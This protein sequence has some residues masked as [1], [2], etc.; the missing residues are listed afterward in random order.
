MSQGLCCCSPCR[1]TFKRHVDAIYPANP[2]EGLVKNKMETLA[3]YAMTSPEKLDRIGEYLE[4]RISRDIYRNRKGLAIIGMEAM[5]QLIKSCHVHTINLFVESYL[6]TVQKLLESP[7]QDLQIIASQ[8]FLAFSQIKEDTPSYH[9]SYNFFIE[10]FSQMCHSDHMDPQWRQ[11]IRLSGLHGLNGVIRKTVN[12]DLAENIW[13]PRHMDKIVPSLLFNIEPDQFGDNDR[14]TPDLAGSIDDEQVPSKVADQILRELVMTASFSSIKS[15]LRPVLVFMKDHNLWDEAGLGH[16][17]HTFE[18]IMYSIQVDL[19]YIVIDKLMSHLEAPKNSMVQKA[20]I[21]IVLSKIIGIGVGD[22]T[23]GPAVLEIIN[24][25]LKHL[26]KSVD[27]EKTY[28]QSCAD[29]LQQ[30]QNALLDALAEYAGH[31]PDFQRLEIMTFIL[32]KIPNDNSADHEL[33]LILMKALY[34]VAEKQTHTTFTSSFSSSL[35]SMLLKLLRAPDQDVRLLVLQTVQILIDRHNNREKL[36]KLVLQPGNLD[37]ESYPN[38]F[39]RADH[40]FVQKSLG[41]IFSDFRQV[42]EEQSNTIEF[43]EAVYSTCALL[44]VETSAIEESSFCLLELVHQVQNIAITNTNL[45]TEN[46]F[47]LHVIAICFLVLLTTTINLPDLDAYVDMIVQARSN[48]APHMLPPLSEQYHPGLD[49]NTPE[50]DVLISKSDIMETLKNAGKDVEKLNEPLPKK[51]T[52][53]SRDSWPEQHMPLSTNSSRRPSTVSSSSI[54]AVDR[55]SMNSSIGIIHSPFKEDT[56]VAAF[57][58]VLEGPSQQEK[59]IKEKEKQYLQDRFLNASLEELTELT[60]K[61]GPDMQ[62][63]LE[64]IFTRVSFGEP[65]RE[66]ESLLVKED[67]ILTCAQP[68]MRYFPELFMY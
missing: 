11:K 1:P 4:Q 16:A 60:A 35:L 7:D 8:S 22:S 38:K 49:P 19:S 47:A 25:L 43:I 23:V 46:R 56:S 67:S 13:D 20:S 68:H 32:G 50:E 48:K 53:A 37:L 14:E 12:E 51:K 18:A 24:D 45:S 34:C 17:I 44:H 36:A 63:F 58:K 33:Q 40:L 64:E 66:T 30:L 3:Y 27:K 5:D 62:E 39:S 10:R 59:E 52:S 26:K 15:I 29:P 28:D 57:K 9:R 31:M 54:T 41:S 21:A 2:E 42:L 61:K 55:L 65:P 6:K